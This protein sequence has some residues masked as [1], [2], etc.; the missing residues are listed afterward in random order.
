VALH[1][2]DGGN[3]AVAAPSPARSH[4]QEATDPEAPFRAGERA[5][6]ALRV[7]TGSLAR[8]SAQA[9]RRVAQGSLRAAGIIV[10]R[11]FR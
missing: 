4:C 7:A 5:Y 8:V 9:K 11:H 10:R 1:D 2:D 3:R 6:G